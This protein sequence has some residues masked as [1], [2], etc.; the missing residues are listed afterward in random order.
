MISEV[1]KHSNAPWPLSTR[2]PWL[3]CP[4]PLW[5]PKMSPDISKC[6][7]WGWGYSAE[8]LLAGN[9][10][11][12]AIWPLSNSS[13][14]Q[15]GN[16]VRLCESDNV[17]KSRGDSPSIK[18]YFKSENVEWIHFNKD[19]DSPRGLLLSTS[20]FKYINI[21]HSTSNKGF[22]IWIPETRL[23]MV[24]AF[25]IHFSIQADSRKVC[26]TSGKK[27]QAQACQSGMPQ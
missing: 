8:S 17:K 16:R 11:F 14:R 4:P 27:T 10:W 5:Q 15:I 2:H 25:V 23:P 19:P 9:H 12:R 1:W 20:S 24:F 22:Q 7:R 21:S 13:R 6:H 3:P 26:E 18:W